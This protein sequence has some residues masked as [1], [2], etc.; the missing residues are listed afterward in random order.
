MTEKVNVLT[1]TKSCDILTEP[2]SNKNIVQ[3]QSL[4]DNKL[5][6]KD[7]NICQ[8]ANKIFGY[9]MHTEHRLIDWRP[10]IIKSSKSNLVKNFIFNLKVNRSY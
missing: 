9:S 4:R 6:K 1:T 7:Y 5:I 8:M 2:I 10:S 3:Y